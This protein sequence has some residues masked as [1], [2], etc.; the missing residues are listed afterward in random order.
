MQVKK[1]LIFPGK[2]ATKK[3]K[4]KKV[5]SKLEKVPKDDKLLNTNESNL[6]EHQDNTDDLE[7][8]RI[9][10]KSTRT[11]VI[12]RQAERDAIRAALQASMKV[13]LVQDFFFFFG[14]ILKMRYM[15]L[16]QDI[17]CSFI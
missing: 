1:R 12:V 5:L 17:W 14:S 15:V 4:S 2:L 16:N 10:R 3:K 7:G 9:V 6:S 8:E 13:V 11:L